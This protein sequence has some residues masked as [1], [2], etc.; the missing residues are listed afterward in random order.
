MISCTQVNAT[1]F[2]KPACIPCYPD[3]FC[4]KLNAVNNTSTHTLS[5]SVTFNA[6]EPNST[7]FFEIVISADPN[8]VIKCNRFDSGS[9]L[10]YNY[11]C[12]GYFM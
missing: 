8:V 7:V 1:F 3:T 6:N 5:G 9:G 11:S 10:S 12:Y 2:G 4:I